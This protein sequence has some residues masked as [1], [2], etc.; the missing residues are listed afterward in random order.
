MSQELLELAGNV[1]RDQR[2]RHIT[3]RH[4]MLA[5]KDDEELDVLFR[6]KARHALGGGVEC[7]DPHDSFGCTTGTKLKEAVEECSLH[8]AH[9]QR[10]AGVIVDNITGWRLARRAGIKHIKLFDIAPQLEEMLENIVAICVGV[11]AGT[12]PAA[13]PTQMATKAVLQLEV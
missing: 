8:I 2:K 12:A 10:A 11:A 4:L 7:R 5:I 13:T 6:L 1:S 9:E 3:P